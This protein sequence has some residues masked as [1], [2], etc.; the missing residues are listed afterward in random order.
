MTAEQFRDIFYVLHNIDLDSLEAAGVIKPGA[1]G[2]TDW[3]RFNSDLT[4]FVL[5]LRQENLEALFELVRGR[6]PTP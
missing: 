3:K 6:M 1:V 2:G 5:K 4:T